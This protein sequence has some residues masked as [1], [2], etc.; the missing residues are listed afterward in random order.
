MRKSLPRKVVSQNL[1]IP[2]T[3]ESANPRRQ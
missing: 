3:L 2:T 1:G